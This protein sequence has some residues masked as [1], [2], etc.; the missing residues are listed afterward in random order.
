M[1]KGVCECI[2]MWRW[3][4]DRRVEVWKLG[5]CNL[6][7]RK[8]EQLQGVEDFRLLHTLHAM[9][10][11]EVKRCRN[12]GWLI[13]KQLPHSTL[14]A[15]QNENGQHGNETLALRIASNVECGK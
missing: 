8:G 3:V 4:V 15:M 14:L 11:V 12:I 6:E 2:S 9:W 7:G 10:N 13:G 5:V 1:E